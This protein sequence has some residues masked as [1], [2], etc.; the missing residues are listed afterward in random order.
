MGTIAITGSASGIGAAC[1]ARLAADGHSVVGVDLR[2]AAVVAD[3]SSAE[4]RVAAIDGVRSACDGCLDGLVTCAGLGGTPT[5]PGALLVDVNYLGTVELLDGLRDSLAAAGAAAVVAIGSNSSTCQPYL[6]V[7]VIEACLAGDAEGARLGADAAGSV[8]AYG[9]T[10]VA[11]TR[12]VRRHAPRAEWIGAGIRANV[13]APGMIETA[14]VA[15][16]RADP[17]MAAALDAF[18]IPRGHAGQPDDI[19]ALVAF[20]LGR[21]ASNLC[22]S[23]LFADGGTDALLRADDWPAPWEPDDATLGRLFSGGATQA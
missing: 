1:A 8:S 19:A 20:L 5:R 13:V 10:K 15:E 17:D 6:P 11:V 4:G 14:L 21:D 16:Q 23:V 7:D 9:A 22:G 3:L 2:D 18:P 12:W